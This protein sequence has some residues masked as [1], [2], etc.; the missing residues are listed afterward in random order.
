MARSE[1]LQPIELDMRKVR[2]PLL[3]RLACAYAH[4]APICLQIQNLIE[5]VVS[6]LDHVKSREE[7]LRNTNGA[8]LPCAVQSSVPHRLRAQRAHMTVSSG[9][10]SCRAFFSSVLA[11]TR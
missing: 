8:P 1:N 7:A 11:S 6:E 9:L 3:S 2:S 10:A 4:R 5:G